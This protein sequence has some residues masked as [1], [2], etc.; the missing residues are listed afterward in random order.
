MGLRERAHLPGAWPLGRSFAPARS[1][2]AVQRRIPHA[3]ASHNARR[4]AEGI[5]ARIGFRIGEDSFVGRLADGRIE[6]ASGA[7]GDADVIFTGTAPVIAGAIYGGQ[8]LDAL[9]AAGALRVEGDRA[10][11]E[12]FVSLFPLPPKADATRPALRQSRQAPG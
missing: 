1:R 8:K 2:P 4:R 3:V 7:S 5:D 12:R 11:A 9:E 6:I 10:L